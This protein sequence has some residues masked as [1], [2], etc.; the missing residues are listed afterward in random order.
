[1]ALSEAFF[2]CF[3]QKNFEGNAVIW[4]YYID[5]RRPST[6]RFLF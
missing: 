3:S 4:Y 2:G 5:K 6:S 1:M